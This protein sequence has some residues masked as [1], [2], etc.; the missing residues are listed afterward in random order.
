MKSYRPIW[1]DTTSDLGPHPRVLMF[2][3][4]EQVYVSLYR[5]TPQLRSIVDAEVVHQ[6][7]RIEALLQPVKLPGVSS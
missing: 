6:R 3:Y 7:N 4:I 5:T 1:P 2:S